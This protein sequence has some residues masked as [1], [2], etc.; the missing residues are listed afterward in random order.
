MFLFVLYC[1]FVFLIV[2]LQY[3]EQSLWNVQ[4]RYHRML[5]DKELFQPD[6]NYVLFMLGTTVIANVIISSDFFF[7]P[8]Q[9]DECIKL[10]YKDDAN[11]DINFGV[12]LYTHGSSVL[13]LAGTSSLDDVRISMD[14]NLIHVVE[15]SFHRGYYLHAQRL[16]TRIYPLLKDFPGNTLNLTGHSM[17]GA[18]ASILAYLISKCFSG[19]TLF[20]YTFGSPKYATESLERY[21]RTRSVYFVH[22]LNEADPVIYKPLDVS[23]RRVGR[24]ITYKIDTG[25]D[26]I[27]H[28]IKIYKYVVKR[29]DNVSIKKRHHRFDEL[30][31]RSVLDIFG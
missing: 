26:N 5:S 6:K 23:L 10:S 20:V 18:L 12:F 1:I 3:F 19:I 4:Y 7:A 9:F 28:S 25:N 24:T 30:I 17:G 21:F 29:E 16:F 11:N 8:M 31:A 22:Y 15:G 2:L 14:T 27:N 13:S